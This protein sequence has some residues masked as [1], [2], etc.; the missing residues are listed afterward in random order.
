MRIVFGPASSTVRTCLDTSS[1]R[2]F[3]SVKATFLPRNRMA[4]FTGVPSMS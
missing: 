1:S 3:V 4:V 2:R